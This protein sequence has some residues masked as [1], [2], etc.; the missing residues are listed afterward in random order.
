[1]KGEQEARARF[2]DRREMMMLLGQKRN[3]AS[4]SDDA[5]NFGSGY[6]MAGSEGYFAL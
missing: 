5:T 6:Q 4:G 2:E 3:A 1:M